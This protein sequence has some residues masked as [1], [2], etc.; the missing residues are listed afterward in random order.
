[1]D[2]VGSWKYKSSLMVV[3]IVNIHVVE[4][5]VE[6]FWNFWRCYYRVSKAED[7]SVEKTGI[8]K[9]GGAYY[10]QC[11]V[12][13]PAGRLSMEKRKINGQRGVS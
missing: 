11:I 4:M 12:V 1:M 2:I 3:G 7:R 13:I 10:I 5:Y 9:K 8:C 6:L